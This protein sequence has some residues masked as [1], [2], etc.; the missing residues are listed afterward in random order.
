MPI[1]DGDPISAVQKEWGSAQTSSAGAGSYVTYPAHQVAFGVGPG[2]RI[3]DVRSYAASLHQITRA[4]VMAVLG[5]AAAISYADNT[6]IYTYPDGPNDQLQWTFSGGSGH[7]G[8]TVQHVSVYWPQGT[9]DLMGQTAPNPSVVVTANPAST[10]TF[11]Q[12]AIHQAPSGYRLDE[13]EWLPA[14]S[15]TTVVNTEAQALYAAQHGLSG[16]LFMNAYGAYRLQFTPAMKGSSGRLRVIY[17]SPQG[18]AIIGTSDL[19]TLH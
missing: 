16:A 7:T 12:F 19:I 11:M 1:G 3:F 9:V 13:L 2:D 5:S 8:N 14:G 4:D 18:S 6:T 15:G 17:E 10:G